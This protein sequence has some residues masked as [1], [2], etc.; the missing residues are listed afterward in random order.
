MSRETIIREVAARHAERHGENPAILAFAPG[1]VE[2]LGNH[3]DYNEGL[4]LAAATGPGTCFA[5]SPAG[6][7][8]C[9]VFSLDVR[10][11]I[12]FDVTRPFPPG[13]PSW[14]AYVLAVLARLGPGPA[15]PGFSA[16]VGSDLPVGA[17][18]SSSAA[19][20]VAAAL[21]LA[22][23]LGVERSR[24]ELAK[25]CR[26]AEAEAAGVRCGLLDQ[27]TSLLAEQGA[28][29][30]T[31]FQSLEIRALDFPTPG[32]LFVCDTGVKRDLA[33]SAYNE[34]RDQCDRAAAFFRS[35]LDHPARS[36]HNG[37]KRC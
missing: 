8:F 12:H 11:E 27:V 5:L 29:L 30:L 26:D 35:R 6:G 23:H 31:D 7:T 32:S 18:L 3:T 22:E 16:T 20:E 15:S 1:R 33:A 10:E 4:V 36:L 37:R 19:L 24:L 13:L 34:R 21:A 17:G 2:I 25:L 14:S 28:L 9:R